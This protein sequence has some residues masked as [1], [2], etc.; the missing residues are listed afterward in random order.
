[1]SDVDP[2]GETAET[3][4]ADGAAALDDA[5]VWFSQQL[6]RTINDHTEGGEHPERSTT[7]RE[8]FTDVRGYDEETVEEKRLGWVPADATT[9]LLQYLNR[10]GHDSDAVRATGLFTEDL[11][12]LWH[13]RYVFPYLDRDGRAAYAIGR[14]TGALGGG[15]AGYDGHPEDFL[16]GKY[17]KLAHTRDYVTVDEPIYGLGS[18]NRDT[19]VLITEGV[20]DAVRAHEAGYACLSPVTTQF[21][22]EHREQL[23]DI[24]EDTGRRAYI[25]QDAERPIVEHA[26]EVDG[27]DALGIEQFGEGIKGA[28]RTAAFLTDA[29][30][31]AYLAE[32]PRLGLDKVDLDDYL[33]EWA[34][35][36]DPVLAGAK[37]GDEHRAYEEATPSS[38]TTDSDG[39]SWGGSGASSSGGSGAGLT[40]EDVKDALG[41]VS[42]TLSYD[43]WIQL[44]YAVHAWDGGDDGKEIF[45][46]WS[47]ASPKWEEPT[48]PNAIDWI[49]SNA[50]GVEDGA[51][52]KV[53]VGTLVARAKEGGWEPPRR[54]DP[55]R[56]AT[57]REPVAAVPLAR[58]DALDHDE[59]RRYAKKR[60][61]DWPTTGEARQRLHD[62][63]VE[64]IRHGD[65]KVIDAPTALGKTHAVATEPWLDRADV[66]DE[67]AVVML[68]ET[69]EARD[70]AHRG[71][72][73]ANVRS[74]RLLGR[75]EACSCA[76]GDH[77]PAR[78]DDEGDPSHVVTVAGEPASEWIRR[79]CDERGLPL[80]V[81][82]KMLAARMDQDHD[83]LPCEGDVDLDDDQEGGRCYSVAQW[84]GVPR[85]SEGE[86]RHD[87]IHATH[88]FARVPSLRNGTNLVFDERPDFSAALSD[89][90][91]RE[92]VAAYLDDAGAPVADFER[93]IARARTP[94]DERAANE[95]AEHGYV[96]QALDHEPDREWY[97]DAPGAHTLAPALARAIWYALDGEDPDANGRFD[98]TVPH[99]PPRL[100]EDANDAAGWNR[101]YVSIVLDEQH[102]VRRLRV[103]PDTGNARSVVGLDAHPTLE[104]WQRNVHP[105]IR[106]R[107]V[108]GPV[109]RAR[110]RRYE[111]GLVVAQVG[112]ATRPLTSGEYF[113]EDGTRAF[114]SALRD[115]YGERW[116]TAITA[117]S[118]ER[119]TGELMD[120]VGVGDPDTLHY[121]EEKSR[122][123]FGDQDVGAV[124]GC[125]DPGD[126]Y[127]LDLLAEA[128]L[129]AR[130]ETT[131]DGERAHGRGFVGP[132]AD[133]AAA[134]LASVRENHVAQAAGRYARNADD[135]EDRA[136][137]YVRTDATPPG[138]VDVETPGVEYVGTDDQRAIVDAL[139]KR[140][141]ATAGELAE[142][143][144]VTERYV[145]DVLARLAD[146]GTVEVREGAGDHGANVYRALAGLD[147]PA[148]V[149]LSP[150]TRNGD[151]WETNTCAFRI[152]PAAPSR[153]ATVDGGPGATASSAGAPT[154]GEGEAEGDP[155]G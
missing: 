99:D 43:E 35:T 67:S 121:G 52:G 32:L 50:S 133:A 30:V 148:Q 57:E 103:S 139:R 110:W 75:S 79:A 97:V 49:W 115:Q 60:D 111:R 78:G 153:A 108:L 27:W 53:T 66:T 80:S 96:S 92:A 19:P 17:A 82:H 100:D 70:Q 127:V 119:R 124:L 22:K 83:Q 54:D 120:D 64:T 86:V 117:A 63:I 114:L 144:D 9:E 102:R 62:R 123:D 26:E 69:T 55:G 132:D 72:Y 16:A 116:S 68:H 56:T 46:E 137:V 2:Q 24:L 15:A 155:P 42:S 90:R 130:P 128:G 131:D 11:R 152:E 104:L 10:N 95:H 89:D 76:A 4:A 126:D 154:T 34:D 25:V 138:F 98:A 1:M 135:P 122:N 18:L 118:V 14:T 91:V 51:D 71:S 45:T 85:D 33:G 47:K 40:A 143:A 59:A 141:T 20:A 44:G 151:V 61:I 41:H 149:N 21:K 38:S 147:G 101:E 145:R 136:V 93:F 113:D 6:D 28:S 13:G 150:E 146:D 37:P 105:D 107:P 36:L 77:D 39:E 73:D 129:D 3:A 140:P 58:L 29:G 125:I 112:D 12:L 109:N 74:T 106:P 142:A 23:V 94:R 48:S 65:Q 88:Q 5:V 31:E 7:A 134:L 81:A 84:D 8:W 87:V